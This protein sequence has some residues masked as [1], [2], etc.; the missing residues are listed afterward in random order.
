MSFLSIYAKEA[1][2]LG[3]GGLGVVVPDLPGVMKPD[4]GVAMPDLLS[5]RLDLDP[6]PE[7]SFFS[8]YLI[9]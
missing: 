9:S 4:L 8:P 7:R 5:M 6:Q 1:W 2:P 3:I